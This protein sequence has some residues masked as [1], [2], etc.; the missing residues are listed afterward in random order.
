[1]FFEHERLMALG[2][3]GCALLANSNDIAGARC[4]LEECLAGRRRLL[5]PDRSTPTRCSRLGG[6]GRWRGARETTRL[7]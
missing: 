5:G 2:N 3:L 7:R 6:W 4:A 1:M